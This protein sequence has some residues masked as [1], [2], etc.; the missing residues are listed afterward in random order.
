ISQNPYDEDFTYG[1]ATVENYKEFLRL[2]KTD[3]TKIK[4]FSCFDLSWNQ[5]LAGTN[6]KQY[7]PRSTLVNG[8]PPSR[9][10]G[11]IEAKYYGMKNDGENLIKQLEDKTVGVSCPEMIKKVKAAIET[12][13]RLAFNFEKER[14]LSVHPDPT[15][16]ARYE[17]NDARMEYLTIL[18]ANVFN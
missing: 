8:I 11:E 9:D 5:K 16:Q 14:R 2:L 18:I 6:L 12:N 1:E 4:T 13:S 7:F 17:I 15:Y 10:F 3:E